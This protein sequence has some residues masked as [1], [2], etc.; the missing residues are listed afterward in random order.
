MRHNSFVA[1]AGLIAPALGKSV[2]WPPVYN[3]VTSDVEI[4]SDPAN[5]DGFKM[6][7]SAMVSGAFDFWYFDV[8][9][10]STD[11]GLNIVFFNTGDLK[12]SQG[13]E[14]PLAMQLSGKFANG[15]EFFVQTMAT[16]G[17]F[18][19]NDEYGVSAD[20]KGAGAS[21]VGT[22]LHKDNVSY[23]ITFDGSAGGLEGTITFKSVR[24]SPSEN[25][26]FINFR[27]WKLI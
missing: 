12:Y 3:N 24:R 10:E 6:N 25:F 20:F 14:Q 16:E 18:I 5:L 17:A 8:A 13:N 22:N 9:S 2:F 15:T 23:T 11:A 19:K 27:D 26:H 7:A 1:A 4:L 21:F